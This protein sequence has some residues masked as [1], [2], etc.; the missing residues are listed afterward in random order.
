MFCLSFF[1]LVLFAFGTLRIRDYWNKAANKNISWILDF[2]QNG[3]DKTLRA[4][5]VNQGYKRAS[6][7]SYAH[8]ICSYTNG[9]LD[10]EGYEGLKKLTYRD[11]RKNG[12]EDHGIIKSL[13]ILVWNEIVDIHKNYKDKIGRGDYVD[14]FFDIM[15]YL[16]FTTMAFVFVPILLLSK[17][18]QIAFP[19]IIVGYLAYHQLLFTNEIELFQMV[20]L[21]IY[22]GLQLMVVLLGI[23]VLRI[24]WFLLHI[25]PGRSSVYLDVNHA[26]LVNNT[27]EYY[28]NVY[29]YPISSEI[30]LKVF[31]NDIGY[32]IMDYC[33][34]MKL[35][36]DSSIISLPSSIDIAD[37]NVWETEWR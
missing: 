13:C 17:I 19:W 32:I 11:L 35:V 24:Q 33:K 15:Q 14:K 37:I 30:V 2:I 3:R 7:G 28:E 36:S 23:K 29:W 27:K 12:G 34:N 6:G 4:I 21:W 26:E 16:V 31:G 18:L 22:I 8:S 20:M 10:S 9:I 1:A 5:S 25:D